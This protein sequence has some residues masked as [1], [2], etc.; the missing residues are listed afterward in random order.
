MA[1]TTATTAATTVDQLKPGAAAATGGDP[2]GPVETKTTSLFVKVLLASAL[3][4]AVIGGASLITNLGGR[5]IAQVTVSSLAGPAKTACN[6]GMKYV[7]NPGMDLAISTFAKL[8][9]FAAGFL[10]AKAV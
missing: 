8:S 6:L 7:V 10:P 1:A 5:D 9:S 3:A 4:L 2:S